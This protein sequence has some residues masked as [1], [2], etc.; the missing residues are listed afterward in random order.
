MRVYFYVLIS[1]ILGLNPFSP[2][3]RSLEQKLM[4]IASG[5]E[6]AFVHIEASRFAF[7]FRGY[8]R[9]VIVE[10]RGLKVGD[11]RIELLRAESR[12]FVFSPFQTFIRNRARL[13]S[14]G[15][16]HWFVTILDEDLEAYIIA[17]SPLARGLQVRIDSDCVTLR[18]PSGLASLLG[19]REPLSMCGR[20]VISEEKN[21]LLDLDHVKAFGVGPGKGVLRP[22]IGLINPILSRTDFN[23]MFS[24]AKAEPVAHLKLK[25]NF[26]EIAMEPGHA[27]VSGVILST[28]REKKAAVKNAGTEQKAGR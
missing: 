1:G 18:R 22:L 5:A 6:A 26:E 13:G 25:A 19:L 16:A 20:L 7:L 10:I 3:E 21:L 11:L 24:R 14:V 2:I 8:C 28:K 4:K 9:R 15:E 12:G 27:V 23:R 17:R